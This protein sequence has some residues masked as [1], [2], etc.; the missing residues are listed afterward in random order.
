VAHLRNYIEGVRVVELLKARHDHM[1]K[2]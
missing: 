1:R 2:L